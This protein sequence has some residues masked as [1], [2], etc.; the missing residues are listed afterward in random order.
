MPP[1]SL[2]TRRS[3]SEVRSPQEH[4]TALLS[5]ATR[6]DLD[7]I[8]E[9]A[10]REINSFVPPL[11]PV[12]LVELALHFDVMQWLERAYVSLCTRPHPLTTTEAT[13]IGSAIARKI[14][15]CR[16]ELIMTNRNVPVPRSPN[17]NKELA[18]KII[19]KVFWPYGPAM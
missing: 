3:G 9:R 15:R 2:L 8:R 11:D 4:W 16:A 10:I 7:D 12:R 19:R 13:R 6:Y 5:I 1:L 18:R 17:E 14:G